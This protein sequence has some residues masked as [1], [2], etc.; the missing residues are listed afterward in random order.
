MP[1]EMKGARVLLLNEPLEIQSNADSVVQY[2][3]ILEKQKWLQS[4]QR[5]K[6]NNFFQA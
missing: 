5:V 1:N 4:E 3:S 6:R 2:H